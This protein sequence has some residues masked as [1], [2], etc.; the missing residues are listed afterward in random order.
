ML[1]FMGSAR[2]AM[3]SPYLRIQTRSLG[4]L[5]FDLWAVCTLGG[6][7][8]LL[9]MVQ[10]LAPL[11][12]SLGFAIVF[13]MLP[14]RVSFIPSGIGWTAAAIGAVLNRVLFNT[15]GVGAQSAINYERVMV[16]LDVFMRGFVAKV[17]ARDGLHLLA[18]H[19]CL[20]ASFTCSK[21]FHTA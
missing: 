13:T 17:L 9:F 3:C 10:M 12:V 2:S 16:S 21:C 20:S 11:T 15:T 1:S 5:V 14:L 4:S 7:S 19:G 8:N 18:A 6:M